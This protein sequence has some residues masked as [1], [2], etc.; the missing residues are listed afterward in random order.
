MAKTITETKVVNYYVKDDAEVVARAM[1]GNAQEGAWTMR[2]GD[3]FIKGGTGPEDVPIGNGKSLAEGDAHL[4][5]SAMVKDIRP[6]TDRLTL[7][8]QLSGGEASSEEEIT[9]EGD[10]GA[11]ASYSLIVRFL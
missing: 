2:L 3:K 7:L 9:N 10:S 1:I 5:V 8:V 4:E 6:E 11:N